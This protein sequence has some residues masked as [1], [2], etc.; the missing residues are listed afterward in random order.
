MLILMLA[1]ITRLDALAP[2]PPGEARARPQAT[3]TMPDTLPYGNRFH[4]PFTREEYK[5]ALLVTMSEEEAEL[6][7]RQIYEPDPETIGIN[8]MDGDLLL[9]ASLSEDLA[10]RVVA[11]RPELADFVRLLREDPEAFREEWRAQR[12]PPEGLMEP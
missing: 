7:A 4:I 9:L 10:A 1:L 12:E 11:Y 5:R 2:V 3:S 6:L 8:L